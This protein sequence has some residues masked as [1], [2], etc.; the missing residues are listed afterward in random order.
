MPCA[1]L[2][3]PG[4]IYLSPPTQVNT[5]IWLS[6]PKLLGIDF[7][8]N[9]VLNQFEQLNGLALWRSLAVN[10]TARVISPKSFGEGN[11]VMGSIFMIAS[12]VTKAPDAPAELTFKELVKSSPQAYVNNQPKPSANPEK[13]AITLGISVRGNLDKNPNAKDDELKKNFTAV[14]YGDSDFMT[15]KFLRFGANRDLALNSI[16]FFGRR[17]WAIFQFARRHLRRLRLK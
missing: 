6:S 8:N 2:R 17:Q 15:N 5:T 16:L 7:H 3:A 12:E 10:M 1:R 11:R 9:Y 4:V 14:V 13:R